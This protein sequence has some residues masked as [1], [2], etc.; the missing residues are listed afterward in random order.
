[1]KQLADSLPVRIGCAAALAL[2][3]G[4]AGAHSELFVLERAA[5][6]RG[7]L[8]RLWTGHL[9]H[10]SPTH[11]AYDVGVA[12]LLACVFGGAL[13]LLWMAPVVAL[14]LL[15]AFPQVD[16]Y[17]GL[18]ACLHAWA[19]AVA[20]HELRVARRWRR[21]LAAGFVAVTLGKG[22]VETWLNASLF[23]TGIDFG[24]PVL[25]ASHLVGALVGLLPFAAALS[26]VSVPRRLRAA[27]A[28]ARS[29]P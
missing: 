4:A 5:V 13:H 27:L 23:T 24:G 6:A 12:A 2:A 15:G 19:V 9:V 1:M 16:H 8:W 20:V 7:E 3:A 28:G 25:H 21:W 17:Y 14:A 11:F 26:G 10:G 18:S 29:D 22:A